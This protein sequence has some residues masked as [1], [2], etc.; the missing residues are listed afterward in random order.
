MWDFPGGRDGG[1]RYLVLG[2]GAEQ[3]AE[4]AV[5]PNGDEL[6]AYGPLQSDD[7]TIWLGTAVL[8]RASDPDQARAVLAP[9]RYAETEVHNWAFGGRPS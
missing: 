1:N 5:P 8:L 4:L 6:V 2:L 9:T 7:G 3:G